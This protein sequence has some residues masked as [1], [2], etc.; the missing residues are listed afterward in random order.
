MYGFQVLKRQVLE[1]SYYDRRASI[2]WVSAA[3]LRSAAVMLRCLFSFACAA[4]S[5][6]SRRSRAT[7]PAGSSAG[8]IRSAQI[9]PRRCSH[10]GHSARQ[11]VRADVLHDPTRAGNLGRDLPNAASP[12]IEPRS[13]IQTSSRRKSRTE[14]QDS[15]SA[16]HE[17]SPMSVHL[18]F[19]SGILTLVS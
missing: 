18:T 11:K 7:R 6:A 13:R 5:S 17:L 4:D 14:P 10:I 12:S 3:T 2:F 19:W 8:P 9:T 1:P 16:V 15:T